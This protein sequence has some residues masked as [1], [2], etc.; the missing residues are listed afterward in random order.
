MHGNVEE[1]CLDSY[2]PY[3]EEP[4]MDP[5]G[6]AGGEMKVSRGGSHNTPLTFLRSANRSGTLA[7][8]K[9]WLIGFR[10]V[11]AEMPPTKPLPPVPSPLWASAVR[12]A[13][14]EW[15]PAVD[16][17]RP[18]STDLGKTWTYSGQPVHADLRRTAA[19]AGPAP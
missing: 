13:K 17:P 9:H 15:R 6:R 3:P 1:W 14:A 7:E 11:S 10:V 19:G 8:D 18:F 16:M 12:A 4:Q 2:G 5:V